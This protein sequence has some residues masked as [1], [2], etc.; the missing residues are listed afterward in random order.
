MSGFLSKDVVVAM[1]LIIA[2]GAPII[3]NVLAISALSV[4][5]YTGHKM[6]PWL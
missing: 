4:A 1:E 3:T 2:M 6:Q 5:Q